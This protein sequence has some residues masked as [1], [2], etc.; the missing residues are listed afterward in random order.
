ML[1]FLLLVLLLHPLMLAAV[2][3]PPAGFSPGPQDVV[4]QDLW[5]QGHLGKDPLANL[6]VVIV[7]HPDG[8]RTT[9]VTMVIRIL[10]TLMGQEIRFTTTTTNLTRESADGLMTGFR[11]EQDENGLRRI[12]VGVVE[13]RLVTGTVDSPSGRSPIRLD[14]P[15]HGRLVGSAAFQFA[16][17]AAVMNP[18]EAKESLDVA[19]VSGDLRLVRF[20]ATYRKPLAEGQREFGLL[21]DLITEP[22]TMIVDARGALIRMDI[23]VGPLQIVFRPAGG[24]V[25]LTGARMDLAGLTIAR[26]N[27]RSGASNTYQFAEGIAARL[28]E[29]AFQRRQGQRLVVQTEADPQVGLAEPAP[30][31]AAEPQLETAAPELRQ[32]VGTTLAGVPRAEQAEALV[33]A[34]RSRLKGDLSRGDASALT[35]WRERIGDCSEHA[36]LLVAALRIAG[37][38]ARIEIGMIFS[39]EVGGWGGHAWVSAWDDQ[40]RRWRHLDAAMTGIPRSCYV[41]TG[42]PSGPGHEGPADGGISILLGQTIEVVKP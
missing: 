3:P 9:C 7:R 13:G 19:L 35:A 14:L 42:S 23:A 25:A 2:E 15:A 10:R 5:Y 36:H 30:L 38:P 29:D 33:R 39:A 4:E 16:R 37:I 31:L 18:G 12:A 17:E 34:V 40:T 6:H 22:M 24:P 1:R 32:W 27:P 41:R 20:T 28:P 8:T 11:I 21:M 26:G